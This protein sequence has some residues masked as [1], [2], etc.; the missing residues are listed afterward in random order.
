MDLARRDREALD[1]LLCLLAREAVREP[2][3]REYPAMSRG[4]AGDWGSRCL[5][6][7]LASSISSPKPTDEC[8]AQP[9]N[10]IWDIRAGRTRISNVKLQSKHPNKPLWIL[11]DTGLPKSHEINYSTVS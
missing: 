10:N 7:A 8:H 9:N 11:S 2:L 6:F 1:V 4:G 5:A 3:V